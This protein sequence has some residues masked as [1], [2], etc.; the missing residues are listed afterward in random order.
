MKRIYYISLLVLFFASC[1]SPDAIDCLKTS[2]EVKLA[3]RAV[4]EFTEV[5]ING[6]FEVIIT[7]TSAYALAIETGENLEPE[8]TTEVLDG[9]LVVTNNNTCNWSRS[10]DLPK[11][12]ISA[13][14]IT[15]ILQNGGGVVKS[16]NALTFPTLGVMS[17]ENSGDFI[18]TLNNDAFNI[19][20]NEVSNYYISGVTNKF[21]IGFYAGDG[22]CLCGDLVAEYVNVFQRGTNDMIVN[23]A[24]TLEGRIISTGNVIYTG[25]A[26]SNINVSEEGLGKLIDKTN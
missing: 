1:D 21:F 23:A 18:L 10:Y 16:A 3:T 12:H 8:I 22:R 7:D 20:N 6:E 5:E 11:V 13:P 9:R 24:T 15:F 2:G 26:P 14:N 4:S 17:E 19:T 25:S